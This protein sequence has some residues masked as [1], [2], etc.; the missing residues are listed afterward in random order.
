V[1]PGD[2]VTYE[3]TVTGDDAGDYPAVPITDDLSDVL[4]EGA[5]VAGSASVSVDGGAAQPVAD[6][7]GDLL[8]WTG[9]VPAGVQAVLTYRVTVGE[10]ASGA[11]VN[12]VR[13]SGEPTDCDAESGLDEDG[14]ACAVLTTPF[15]PT[16]TKSVESLTQ[17]DDG[18]WTIQYGIDVVNP[19]P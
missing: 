2:V 18:S 1:R 3:V 5:F 7:I 12:T 15:A 10:P 11:L 4:D 14:L 6:P 9:T 13:T 16:I 8:T 19:A 17:A